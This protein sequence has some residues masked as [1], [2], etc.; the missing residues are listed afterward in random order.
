MLA[1]PDL[2]SKLGLMPVTNS[3]AWIEAL[4]S[5]GDQQL[6]GHK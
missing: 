1:P 3:L 4:Q 6:H 2:E 5:S